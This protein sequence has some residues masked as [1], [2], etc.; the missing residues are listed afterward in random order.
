MYRIDAVPPARAAKA[1]DRARAVVREHR[2]WVRARRNARRVFRDDLGLRPGARLQDVVDAVSAARGRP[3]T[4]LRT[5]LMPPGVSGFVVE[6]R[7][8]D[9][10]VVTATVSA[11]LAVHISLHELRHLV[12]TASGGVHGP[13]VAGHGAFGPDTLRNLTTEL[14]TLPPAVVDEVLGGPA[15]MRSAYDDAEER[16]CELF[17]TIVLPMLDLSDGTRS[18]S[19]VVTAFSN[20]RSL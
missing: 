5:E 11:R 18:T 1:G 17:A 7:T 15:R 20:R 9:T 13:S 12:P 2:A 16:D 4:L 3:L 6:G 19:R 10:I 8:Q 14:S